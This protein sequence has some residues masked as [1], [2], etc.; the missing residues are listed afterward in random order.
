MLYISDDIVTSCSLTEFAVA[1]ENSCPKKNLKK[2]KINLL[3]E[4]NVNR[5][6]LKNENIHQKPK[7]SK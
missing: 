5:P 4:K 3:I 7:V 6:I 1:K 2:S